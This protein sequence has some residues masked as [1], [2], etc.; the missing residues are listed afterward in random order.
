M[1]H[2]KKNSKLQNVRSTCI[3]YIRTIQMNPYEWI[4][5]KGWM[6]SKSSFIQL[7]PPAEPFNL[8][9]VYMDISIYFY[10]KQKQ[11]ENIV[12]NF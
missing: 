2:K 4:P 7:Q 10:K 1:S 6:M 12:Y 11:Q 8:G 5:Q 9:H 3:I